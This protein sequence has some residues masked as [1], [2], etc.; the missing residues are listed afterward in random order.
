MKEPEYFADLLTSRRLNQQATGVL[1]DVDAST[2]SRICAGQVRARPA[3]IVKLAQAL[4]IAP[5]R[6]KAMCDAHWFAAHPD[7]VVG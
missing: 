1:G 2:I 4:G 3:T 5:K 7:E 6:M